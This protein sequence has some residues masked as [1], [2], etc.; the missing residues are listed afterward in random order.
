MAGWSSD[1]LNRIGNAEELEVSPRRS[2]GTLQKPRTIWVVRID[3]DL[4][5]RSVRGRESDWFQGVQQRHEAHISAGGVE[6]DVSLVEMDDADL[7]HQ[8]DEAYRSKYS[9]YPQHVAPMVVPK[10]QATTLRLTP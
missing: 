7:N 3:D 10:S 8:I 1:E 5:I 6:K 2:N 9:R 4:Y